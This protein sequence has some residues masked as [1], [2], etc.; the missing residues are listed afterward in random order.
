MT[1]QASNLRRK[2]ASKEEVRQA[3]TISIISGKGGV[4][5]SNIAL[6]FSI[7]LINQQK[8]V[9]IFD[10]DVG[11]GNINILLG[12]SPKRTIVDLLEENL[13]IAE[14]VEHGPNNL[15]YVAGGSGLSNFLELTTEK[16]MHFY[17]QFEQITKEYDYIIFDM[18]AGITMDS[19]FFILASDESIVVTT[20]EPTSITDAYSMIKQ[21][22]NHGYNSEINI[23][24]NRA[25]SHKE[26]IHALERF[27]QVVTQFLHIQTRAMGVIPEDQTVTKAVI[28]QTPYMLLNE[29]SKVAKAMRVL[30]ESFLETK[31][32]TLNIEDTSFVNK[33][34]NLLR[35]KNK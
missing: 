21:L 19:L 3:K 28:K 22:V 5:K 29:K 10:L 13:Q 6:N 7:E 16:K 4:G 31:T 15:A 25:P 1:D 33:L 2:L 20:P 23:I 27:Q 30:T 17:N 18:G 9:I 11:M 34:I 24:L 8:K 14:V 12:L 32:D 26:G 35:G